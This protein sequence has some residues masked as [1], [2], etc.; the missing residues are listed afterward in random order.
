MQFTRCGQIGFG[1][2]GGLNASASYSEGTL[3]E[4]DNST[5]GIFG[6]GSLILGG[7]GSFSHDENGNISG[8]F[9]QGIV[10]A[11]AA[12]GQ[13]YCSTRTICFN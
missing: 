1:L 5:E 8:G 13:Q 7:G 11:G 12:G 6:Q 3:C 4:G 2:E 10:G 9:I